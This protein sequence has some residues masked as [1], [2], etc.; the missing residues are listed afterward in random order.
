MRQSQ[1]AVQITAPG[2]LLGAAVFLLGLGS[3]L[4]DFLKVPPLRIL[5]IHVL[6]G[7]VLLAVVV[8]SLLRAWPAPGES[9]ADSFYCHTRRLA[10][11][12]YGLL[13]VMAAARV[14]LYLANHDELNPHVTIFSR[15]T[16]LDALK[17][18]QQ[19][20][21]VGLLAIV[22]IRLCAMLTMARASQREIA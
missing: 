10:R 6:F 2:R 20:I 14:C 3:L 4:C 9:A 13:Y 21:G 8:G 5:N 22:L 18:F 12:V 7:V 11:W 16:A 17:D 19:Y 15:L 1:N